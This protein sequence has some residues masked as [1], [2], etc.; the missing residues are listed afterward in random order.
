MDSTLKLL[1]NMIA[2]VARALG[3]KL[4][5]EVAFVGGC[6]T[7]LLVTDTFTKEGIR[8]TEDVDLIVGV[9]GYPGWVKLQK[10]LASKGFSASPADEHICR[11][12]LGELKVDFMPDDENVLGF[13]NRWYRQALQNAQDFQLLDNLV[14]RLV[15]APYFIATKLEA[16][17]GRGNNDPISSHDFE[18]ILTII[19]GRPSLI[20]ELKDLDVPVRE[21]VAAEIG[22]VLRHQSLGYAVL[23]SVKGDNGRAD[24][25]HDRLAAISS[26]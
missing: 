19:D 8:Y 5:Q 21:Y 18:D 20:D 23:G 22:L 10:E 24:L 6:A 9:M 16:Y 25:I 12:R 13:S 2:T 1:K 17:K 4:L 3:D 15:T 26:L 7:G 11:M 14:I